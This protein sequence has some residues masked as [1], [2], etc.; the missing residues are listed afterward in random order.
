MACDPFSMVYTALWK[1][2]EETPDL[3]ELVKLRNRIRYDTF[4]RDPEKR[5]YLDADCPELAL[6][7]AGV[8]GNLWN[9]STTSLVQRRYSWVIISGDMRI[10][11]R[12]MPVE[13]ALF[14][15]MHGWKEV[16]GALTWNDKNFVHRA[17][18]L[19]I[20]EGILRPMEGVEGPRGWSAVWAIQVDLSFDTKDLQALRS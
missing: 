20:Q 11:E 4:D 3:I 13:W 1:M 17:S 2:A 12:L 6:H 18:M 9:S 7:S 19:D 8:T 16:L 14:I 10:T 15:A 5:N